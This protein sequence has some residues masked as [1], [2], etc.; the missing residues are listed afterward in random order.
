MPVTHSVDTKQTTTHL[1]IHQNY[2]AQPVTEKREVKS[3]ASP[4]SYTAA[5]FVI[6]HITENKLRDF[7]SDLFMAFLFPW[8]HYKTWKEKNGI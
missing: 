2:S 6:I 7:N 8:L 4:F 1:K 3:V 5:K